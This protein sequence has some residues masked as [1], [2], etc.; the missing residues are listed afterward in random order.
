MSALDTHNYSIPVRTV[1]ELVKTDRSLYNPQW[2]VSP[3]SSVR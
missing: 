1:Q 2:E 3:T